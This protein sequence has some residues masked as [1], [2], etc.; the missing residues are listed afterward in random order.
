MA[1]ARRPSSSKSDIPSTVSAEWPNFVLCGD[2]RWNWRDEYTVESLQGSVQNSDSR[3]ACSAFQ[4]S[5]L[6]H[7]RS[8]F[9]CDKLIEFDH[10]RLNRPGLLRAG[11]SC[12]TENSFRC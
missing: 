11:D 10:S 7:E 2:Q 4:S 9:F 8:P 1:A 5:V 6:V 3:R 12:A